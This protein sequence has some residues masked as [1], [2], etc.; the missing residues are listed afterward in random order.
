MDKEIDNVS[1]QVKM[2][3]FLLILALTTVLMIL[4]MWAVFMQF[5]LS[6]IIMKFKTIKKMGKKIGL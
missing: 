3:T 2:D 4:S 6:F 1:K 5:F